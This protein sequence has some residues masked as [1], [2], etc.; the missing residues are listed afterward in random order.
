MPSTA[1]HCINSAGHPCDF[2]TK[3]TAV[4]SNADG[5]IKAVNCSFTDGQVPFNINH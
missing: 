2:L 4:Y 1:C 3:A 5:A